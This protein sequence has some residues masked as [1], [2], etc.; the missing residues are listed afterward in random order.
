MNTGQYEKNMKITKEIKEDTQVI[1]KDTTEIK[2]ETQA[3]KE[4]VEKLPAEMVKQLTVPMADQTGAIMDS[5]KEQADRLERN[6]TRNVVEQLEAINTAR[7]GPMPHPGGS[8]SSSSTLG[9][10]ASSSA[11]DRQIN[12]AAKLT[13]GAELAA[14]KK[15]VKGTPLDERAAAKEERA[16]AKAEDTMEMIF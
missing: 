1:K 6:I 12:H 4:K 9:S 3:I 10:A 15:K 5:M 14:A 7:W 13:K 2:A 16:K 8:S 11:L